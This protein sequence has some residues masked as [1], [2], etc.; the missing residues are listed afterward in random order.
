M[1][2]LLEMHGFQNNFPPIYDTDNGCSSGDVEND[3]ILVVCHHIDISELPYA[4]DV[5]LGVVCS[6]RKY[7][8]YAWISSGLK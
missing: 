8:I 7:W 1:S 4:F 3:E 2:G 5:L 6:Y